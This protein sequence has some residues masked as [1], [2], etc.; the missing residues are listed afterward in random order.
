MRSGVQNARTARGSPV[1]S[2]IASAVRRLPDP[3]STGLLVMRDYRRRFGRYPDI[4][5]PQT[6]NEKIQARKLFDRRTQLSTWADK[7]AVRDYVARRIG[8][9]ALPELYHVTSSPSDIPFEKLPAKYVVNPTHGSG[10]VQIIRDGT[11]VNKPRLMEC[12]RRWLATNYFK[13]TREWA[14]KNIPPRIIIEEFLDD[15]TGV[16][17]ADFK[18]FVFGGKVKVIQVDID[19]HTNHKRNLYDANWNRLDC[20]FVYPNCETDV[21]RPATLETMVCYAELLSDEID[22]VRVDLYEVRGKVYFGELTNT[23]ESGFGR[24]DPSSWDAALGRFWKMKS[25]LQASG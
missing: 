6:F 8:A 13:S 23:P 24:F 25:G 7:Y 19:R 2:L 21:P 9:G 17:P 11:S 5:S 10:W 12:C 20:R 16:A 15:G 3:I 1:K 18:L 14:Y 22:F 4:F